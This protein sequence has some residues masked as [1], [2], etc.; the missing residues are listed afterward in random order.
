MKT[1]IFN[2][3]KIGAFLALILSYFACSSSSTTDHRKSGATVSATDNNDEK[4]DSQITIE[5][6]SEIEGDPNESKS[7]TTIDTE[8]GIS[9]FVPTGLV[10]S[11][12]T[13]RISIDPLRKLFSSIPKN[14]VL[15]NESTSIQLKNTDD[16]KLDENLISQ[17]Y[18]LKIPFDPSKVKDLS[19]IGILTRYEEDGKEYERIIT[20][21]T[22]EIATSGEGKKSEITF[23]ASH[24]I[25]DFQLMEFDNSNLTTEDVFIA[26]P[27]EVVGLKCSPASAYAATVSWGMS[28]GTVAAYRVMYS[29]NEKTI[30]DDLACQGSTTISDLTGNTLSYTVSG[31]QPERKYFFRVCSLNSR[32]PEPN[33]SPGKV[34]EVTTPNPDIPVLQLV[35]T[36]NLIGSNVEIFYAKNSN[37]SWDN[38]ISKI[39]SSDEPKVFFEINPNNGDAY[40]SWVKN[41]KINLKTYSNSW[42]TQI[43][44]ESGFSLMALSFNPSTMK[45]NFVLEKITGTYEGDIR[46]M[47][48]NSS[49][50]TYS[51]LTLGSTRPGFN[52]S[53]YPSQGAYSV[54][55][56][57][58]RNFLTRKDSNP[59]MNISKTISGIWNSTNN[60][61]IEYPSPLCPMKY[62]GYQ[63]Y[64]HEVDSNR[65]LHI[66]YQCDNENNNT[67]LYYGTNKTGSFNYQQIYEFSSSSSGDNYQVDALD[68]A[69]DEENNI[70][71][72]FAFSKNSLTQ[73]IVAATKLVTSSSFNL[74]EKNTS[75]TNINGG[76]PSVRSLGIAVD[77][78]HKLHLAYPYW[79]FNEE[80]LG[81]AKVAY[82]TNIL[83]TFTE[84]LILDDCELDING[85]CVYE[86][87]VIGL[88]INNMPRH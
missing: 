47:E 63:I 44:S 35:Y 83:G 4:E 87:T 5:T 85:H 25:A 31:L 17:N 51:F 79:Y 66:V 23:K 18:H 62:F 33:I 10:P 71:V 59:S 86:A 76:I 50:E 40:I 41:N 29:E 72:G 80:G 8:S 3:L 67:A 6:S 1:L 27:T 24:P 60:D 74:S 64:V 36:T 46:E 61:E 52:Q 43:I 82:L 45:P 11:E 16:Q 15:L 78:N 21:E 49:T 69:L 58:E 55:D 73:K 42:Q 75:Y 81:R 84:S 77:H 19:K 39:G 9:V 2:I 53:Q 68:M 88:R 37:A 32:M 65:A 14:A 48:W 70:Y 54:M 26:R 30:T 38:S 28:A 7:I 57:N 20:P 22:V 56:N 12:T 34:C 13:P